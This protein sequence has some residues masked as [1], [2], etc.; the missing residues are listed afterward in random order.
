VIRAELLTDRGAAAESDDFFRSRP[1]L[2]AEGVG[3][4]LRIGDAL[5]LPV[6]V[7]EIDDAGGAIDGISPYGYPGSRGELPGPPDPADVDWSAAG[8]V[9]LFVRDRIGGPPCLAGGTERSLVQI[10]DPARPRGVRSRLSEQIRSNER[11]GWDVQ[12][13]AGPQASDHERAAFL[14]I[15]T[16]TMT[17]AAASARYLYGAEYFR[18]I[19]SFAD[20]FLLFARS[21]AGNLE[22]A[23]I[24]ARSDGHLH[25]YLGGTA[26]DALHASP[27]KNVVAGMIDLADEL[28]LPLNLGGGVRPGDGL[29]GFKRGF[30][31]AE[32][33]FLTHEVVCDAAAYSRLAV[34][35]EADGFFPA[36]RAPA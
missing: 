23:A 11:R 24:V 15:Y 16:E 32:A 17:R 8:L 27:F 12:R 7:R 10:H 3:H 34:G 33:P 20:S 14:A 26:D 6:I 31:N 36:Y 4:T 1:F 21:P 18:A 35:R 19:L 5:A 29:E 30:A 2:D 13:V 22:A 28:G 25:Y 9:S